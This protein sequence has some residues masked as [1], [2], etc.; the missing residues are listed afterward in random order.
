[1]TSNMI[2][3]FT[4]GDTN[5]IWEVDKNSITV[6]SKV[7]YAYLV[8]NGHWNMGEDVTHRFVPGYWKSGDTGD[9]FVYDPTAK[10]GM[11]LKRKYI[12]GK[13]FFAKALLEMEGQIGEIFDSYMAELLDIF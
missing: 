13:K 5:S 12:E 9:K 11:M 1:V 6:G 7:R 2:A 10:G 8:E 4:F 3:S